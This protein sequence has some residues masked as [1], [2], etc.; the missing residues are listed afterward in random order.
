[1]HTHLKN[2]AN[3]IRK[4]SYLELFNVNCRKITLFKGYFLNS[5][6]KVN[7]RLFLSK[8]RKYF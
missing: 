4:L 6:K 2:Y 1:M 5:T 8:L 7:Y 3:K